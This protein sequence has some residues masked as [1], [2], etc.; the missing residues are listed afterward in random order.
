VGRYG[1]RVC[2]S[3]VSL[4]KVDFARQLASRVSLFLGLGRVQGRIA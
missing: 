1:D 2:E 3:L 4:P